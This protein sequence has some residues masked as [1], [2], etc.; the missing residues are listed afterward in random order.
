[1]EINFES[2]RAGGL[3]DKV[4]AINTRLRRSEAEIDEA[5]CEQA[6]VMSQKVVDSNL[7]KE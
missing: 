6:K 7:D 1:M 2:L 5:V 4:D 3:E